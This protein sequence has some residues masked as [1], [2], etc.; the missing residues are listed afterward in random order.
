VPQNAIVDES[1]VGSDAGVI[2]DDDDD[3]MSWCPKK[4]IGSRERSFQSKFRIPSRTIFCAQTFPHPTLLNPFA[5]WRFPPDKPP[6]LTSIPAFPATFFALS[7]PLLD[8]FC[9][10]VLAPYFSPTL[11]TSPSQNKTTQ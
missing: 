8:L 4:K 10:F 9:P 1:I 3:V 6:G 11:D 7:L 5:L 2:E